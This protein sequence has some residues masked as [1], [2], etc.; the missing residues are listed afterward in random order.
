MRVKLYGF[1]KIMEYY[2]IA[3]SKFLSVIAGPL[4]DVIGLTDTEINELTS[5]FKVADG[6]IYYVHFC[7]MIHDDST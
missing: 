3:E 6:R 2:W 7:E 1:N 5:Y 4:K